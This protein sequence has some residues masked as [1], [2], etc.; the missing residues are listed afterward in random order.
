MPTTLSSPAVTSLSQLTKLV[1]ERLEDPERTLWFRGCA[2]FGDHTL[3]AS[4]Y[5]HPTYTTIEQFVD[6]ENRMLA[7]FRQR[8]IPFV[9]RSLT[10]DWERLFFMQ[11]FRIPTRLLDWTENPF[12][13]LHFALSDV[14]AAGDAAVWMLDPIEWNRK[15][16]AHISFDEGVLSVGDQ[17]LDGYAP[18]TIDVDTLGNDP[19]AIYG[20]YNSARIVAQR[21]VFTISGKDTSKMEETYINNSYPQDC[22]TKIRIAAADKQPMLTRLFRMGFTHSAIFPDLEGL[23]REMRNVFRFEG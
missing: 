3:R 6:L 21:G 19:V 16:L 15:A 13:A 20:F 22:L 7:R 1:E 17:R 8:S 5:R 11:H 14:T 10:D 4:L 2:K 9:E 12:V 23:A 18:G